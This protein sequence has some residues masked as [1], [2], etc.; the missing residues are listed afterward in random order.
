MT[1]S[2]IASGSDETEGNGPGIGGGVSLIPARRGGAARGLAQTNPAGRDPRPVRR[3]ALFHT[4]QPGEG[5]FAIADRYRL[6]PASLART[7]AWARSATWIFKKMFETWFR[8]VFWL[9]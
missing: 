8:T 4:V 3:L 7:M 9:R 5:F 2:R 6:V 1:S